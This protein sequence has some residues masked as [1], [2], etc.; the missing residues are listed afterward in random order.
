MGENNKRFTS[1]K[2]FGEE[3]L[4]LNQEKLEKQRKLQSYGLDISLEEVGDIE[5]I[6]ETR[7]LIT[8]YHKKTNEIVTSD[9]SGKVYKKWYPKYSVGISTCNPD[10]TFFVDHFHSIN[11][12][13][14][15]EEAGKNALKSRR[16]PETKLLSRA[17]ADV[18]TKYGD[19]CL[20]LEEGYTDYK[21]GPYRSVSL[22]YGNHNQV[23]INY[24]NDFDFNRYG[25][26]KWYYIN[27][28]KFSRWFMGYEDDFFNNPNRNTWKFEGLNDTSSIYATKSCKD[29]N[30][31][32]IFI[33]GDLKLKE[34]IMYISDIFNYH[35]IKEE[36]K[37]YESLDCISKA[38]FC[39]YSECLAILKQGSTIRMD[40]KKER[41]RT[42]DWI[43]DFSSDIPSATAQEFTVADFENILEQLE[44]SSLSE[45]VKKFVISELESYK[46][47][48]NPEDFASL[49]TFTLEPYHFED[50]LGYLEGKN[51]TDLVEKGIE[52]VTS[53]FCMDI[54][55]F[56]GQNPPNQSKEPAYV[57]KN[58]KRQ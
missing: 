56:L 46:N 43:I 49:H 17:Y 54:E 12:V 22:Y 37:E 15:Y 42:H 3:Y 32:V 57:K 5:I 18:S 20:H 21:F 14:T 39:N 23:M 28:N 48:H 51:L 6:E 25:L 34:N 2:E 11:P 53:T 58:I 33:N 30:S 8:Y 1:F 50:M 55:D 10:K 16:N 9:L 38:Y 36:L 40:Y 4:K 29:Y 31:G 41:P 52:T 24:R 45:R 47:I 19:F 13:K 44:I 35:K 7:Q 26:L 27:Q